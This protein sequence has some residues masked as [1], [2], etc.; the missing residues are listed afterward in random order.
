MKDVQ[1]AW[2]RVDGEWK[3]WVM[4]AQSAALKAIGV[5]Q[6]GLYALEGYRPRQ[7]PGKPPPPNIAFR[8]PRQTTLSTVPGQKIGRYGGTVLGTFDDIEAPEAKR[9]VERWA[10]E[11]VYCCLEPSKTPTSNHHPSPLLP[12]V[13]LRKSRT[14]FHACPVRVPFWWE[15]RRFALLVEQGKPQCSSIECEGAKAS[16][17]STATPAVHRSCGGPTIRA[18]QINLPT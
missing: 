5:R 13:H 1:I 6:R 7:K 3:P 11:G 4:V 9:Q 10:R 14:P 2:K 8:G 12:T 18:G 17:W 16:V 15:L